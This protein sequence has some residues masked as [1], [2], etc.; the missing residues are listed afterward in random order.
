MKDFPNGI[1]SIQATL[2]HD[3]FLGDSPTSQ[4][5]FS[6]HKNIY[7]SQFCYDKPDEALKYLKDLQKIEKDAEKIANINRNIADIYLEK[8]FSTNEN[9]NH[10]KSLFNEALK[11]Y[12]TYLNF[13]AEPN[14]DL[15]K[16]SNN[17]GIINYNLGDH[18]KALESYD[19][20]LRMIENLIKIDEK[21]DDKIILAKINHNIGNVYYD[22]ENYTKSLFF[23][24]KSLAIFKGLNLESEYSECVYWRMSFVYEKMGQH[25]KFL[26]CQRKALE[27]KSNDDLISNM[28][29]RVVFSE[30]D[31]LQ[32]HS[33]PP[34]IQIESAGALDKKTNKCCVIS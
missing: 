25:E 13:F 10:Q 11:N 34:E 15:V 27:C 32:S 21:T 29:S 20:S 1:V 12:Q 22:L 17:V 19:I 26:E 4:I 18:E 6:H 5:K 33:P 24:N 9:P 28:Q 14:Q 16:I 31:T 7:V 30:F 3:P 8:A 23:F 2:V